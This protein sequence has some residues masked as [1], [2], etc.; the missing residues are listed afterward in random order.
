LEDGESFSIEDRAE[1]MKSVRE[2]ST[3]THK[4][5]AVRN[6]EHPGTHATYGFRTISKKRDKG[7]D[8]GRG[9]GDGKEVGRVRKGEG[10]GAMV[11][12]GRDDMGPVEKESAVH[13]RCISSGRVRERTMR[14]RVGEVEKALRQRLK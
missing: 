8:A 6:R 5:W 7:G 4:T 9:E 11:K 3:G 1:R 13:R 14:E 12:G 10:G 2:G